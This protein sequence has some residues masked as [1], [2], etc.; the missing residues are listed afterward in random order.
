MKKIF[1]LLCFVVMGCVACD[2]H[3]VSSP[4]PSYPVRLNL[5]LSLEDLELSGYY[6]TK[7]YVKGNDGIAASEKLGY[8]GVLVINGGFKGNGDAILFAFD[9][10]C[11][12]EVP[13]EVSQ[14]IRVVADDEGYCKCPK[15]GRVYNIGNGSG[16]NVDEN[17]FLRAYR[18]IDKGDRIYTVVN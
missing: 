12:Y 11:P 17:L 14:S 6:S 1:I 7:M 10:A 2:K 18:V 9:L 8:A 16:K 3:E 5:D 13:Y 15:C 4:V